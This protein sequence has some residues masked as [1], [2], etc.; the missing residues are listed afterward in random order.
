M[1]EE[2]HKHHKRWHMACTVRYATAMSVCR[3][4]VHSGFAIG[5]RIEHGSLIYIDASD[6]YAC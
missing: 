2:N 3:H 1:D 5:T 4:K 6:M